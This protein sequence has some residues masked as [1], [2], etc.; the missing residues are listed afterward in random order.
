MSFKKNER[1]RILNDNELRLVYQRAKEF[2]YPYGPIVQLIILTGQRRTETA[3][4]NRNWIE[5]DCV[6]Y[7][8][9]F[10]KNKREHRI[11]LPAQAME[12]LNSL[13][14]AGELYF[15]SRTSDEK[16]FNGWGKSKINFDE[17]FYVAPYTLHDLRRTYS[18]K[19][20][21]LGTL[22]HVTEKLLNHISGSIS[23]IAAVYNRYSYMEEMREAVENY[24]RFLNGLLR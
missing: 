10:T 15:P 18:S 22:L 4:L 17:P 23:G 14:E 24:D 2:P 13:P 5:G 6:V 20:A 1:T 3:S 11:P 19:M 8:Q 21:E 7:P 16:P 12:L 9:G